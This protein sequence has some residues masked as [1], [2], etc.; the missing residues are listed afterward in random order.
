MS[1]WEVVQKTLIDVSIFNI[2]FY[3]GV[4]GA[5]A[6]ITLNLTRLCD[7]TFNFYFEMNFLTNT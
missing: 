7:L 6:F 4:K 3:D 2:I 1:S 5:G